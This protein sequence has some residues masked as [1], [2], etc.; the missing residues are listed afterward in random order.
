MVVKLPYM[1]APGVIPKTLTK[2]REAR[3]PERFTQDYLET[4]LGIR[5]GNARAVLPL[6]KRMGFLNQDGS[7]TTLY[8]QFRN[9]D[10]RAVA[11]AEGARN[12]YRDVF[13]RNEFAFNLPRDKFASLVTEMTGLEKDGAVAK[14]IVGTF[15]ILK[16]GADFEGRLKDKSDRNGGG[17]MD[18]TGDQGGSTNGQPKPPAPP[19]Q[20]VPP[21]YQP[22]PPPLQQP[23]TD[24]VQFRVGYTINLN[25]PETTN[26]E[27]FNAIF[28]A[29]KEHL[30]K[31]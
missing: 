23:A 28:K 7:P 25:L 15:F 27:V 24:D 13:N 29:L 6:L 20:Q 5:G 14:A 22:P 17:A 4:M 1:V 21:Q 16:D 3:R 12:A 18:E 9:D 31:N 30:L 26:P 10:T 19:P 11:Q 2:I 8:D